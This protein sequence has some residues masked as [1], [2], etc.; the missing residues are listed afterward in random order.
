[1]GGWDGEREGGIK[2]EGIVRKRGMNKG[3]WKEGKVKKD[4]ENIYILSEAME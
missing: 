1:M 3:R 4:K 2:D